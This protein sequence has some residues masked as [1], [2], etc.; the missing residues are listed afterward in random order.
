MKTLRVEAT[1]TE[2]KTLV[3]SDLPFQAGETVEVVIRDRS[4][5]WT[6]SD[7]RYPLRGKLAQ[8]EEPLRPAWLRSHFRVEDM[9]MNL[10]TV[11]SCTTAVVFGV[12][13]A[14]RSLSHAQTSAEPAKDHL[15]LLKFRVG[16][17]LTQAVRVRADDTFYVSTSIADNEWTIRGKAH[18][19]RD[20]E[21]MNVQFGIA[22]QVRR[23][24]ALREARRLNQS[25]SESRRILISG[26]EVT[27]EHP[28]GAT[29]SWDVPT[30]HISAQKW[31]PT[32]DPLDALDTASSATTS[33]WCNP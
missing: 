31:E 3:L 8:Y 9:Q 16:N 24:L 26:D 29:T 22:R 21:T 1:L 6:A 15:F 27:V 14:G 33:G 17:A 13:F 11:L 20:G 19:N 30:L 32:G 18:A 2:D 4:D 10:R 12:T 7:D 25:L 5:T 23:P 28:S